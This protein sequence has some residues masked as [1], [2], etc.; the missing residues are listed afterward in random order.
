MYG[1][2]CTVAEW[3]SVRLGDMAMSVHGDLSPWLV[4]TRDGLGR[5]F[6]Y[7]A[8]VGTGMPATGCESEVATFETSW[9]DCIA[10]L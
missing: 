8:K 10:D 9:T 4:A 5:S 2:L 3:A 6:E 7:C 1:S